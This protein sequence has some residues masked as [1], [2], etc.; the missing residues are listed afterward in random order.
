MKI[1]CTSRPI[2]PRSRGAA[3][4]RHETRGGMRWTRAALLTMARI[5]GRQNRVVL[6]PRRWRQVCGRQLPQ[7]TVARKP[8][9]R[10]ERVISRKTIAQGRPG[11]TGGPVVTTLVCLF[12]FRTRGYGCNGHPAF[13]AP[14]V[15]GRDV[16]SSTRTLFASREG[17]G[18]SPRHCEEQSDEAIHAFLL[19]DGL[20]RLCSQ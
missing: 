8:G 9:H 4:D 20:L 2:P 11:E 10:G 1:R 14:S 17:A 7:A 16:D 19:P 12:R 6:T 3:R 18:M 13:P 5:R 15:S